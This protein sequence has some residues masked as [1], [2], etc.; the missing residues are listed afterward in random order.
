MFQRKY[1]LI[2][3][4]LGFLFMPKQIYACAVK[5]SLQEKSRCELNISKS[6]KKNQCNS[7]GSKKC[8]G[9]CNNP[10]CKCPASNLNPTLPD[11]HDFSFLTVEVFSPVSFLT[12]ESA[13]SKGF[14]SI[15][16]I[17]KIG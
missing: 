12:Y 5:I 2:F 8:P 9:K 13:V 15:W 4:L 16:L 7:C 10:L 6:I 11:R 3:I 14:Q 1:I 17:P